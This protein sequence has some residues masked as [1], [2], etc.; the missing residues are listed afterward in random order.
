MTIPFDNLYDYIFD[1][2]NHNNKNLIMH[3]FSP[4]GAR[5]LENLIVHNNAEI[6]NVTINGEEEISYHY[7][8]MF[9]NDQEPLNFDFYAGEYA[10]NT[11]ENHFFSIE[12]KNHMLSHPL[13]KKLTFKRNI[14]GHP[15]VPLSIYD[16]KLILHSEKNSKDLE[17][18]EKNEF[19]GVYYWC[20]ALIAL[21]W[22]RFAKHDPKLKNIGRNTF[23]KSF[24]IYCR[25]WSGSREYRLS[26][27]NKM[28]T[29]GVDLDSAIHFNEYDNHIHFSEFVPENQT[30]NIT[31][32]NIK[33]GRFQKNNLSS[34]ALSATYD[35]SHYVDAAID[36][37]LETV[38]DAEKIHL[39]E[40]TLRPIACGKP[41]IIVSENGTLEYLKSYG[42]ETF[43]NL[44]DESYD[45]IT[46][47]VARMDA[48]TK[49]MKQISDLSKK[50]KDRLFSEMHCIA[51]RNKDWF[52][53]DEFFNIVTNE[54]KT[55]LRSALTELDDPKNQTGKEIRRY[56]RA[57]QMFKKYMPIE[58]KVLWDCHCITMP[59]RF[60]LSKKNIGKY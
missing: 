9:C 60:E 36:V 24:N 40:K 56:I 45:S 10:K 38:Y 14:A 57:F 6:I 42:F 28:I 26:L 25:A 34:S 46:D 51:K 3:R 22:Y 19:L 31:K 11:R 5:N 1:L 59:P 43:G 48:I 50:E 37:V 15:I 41:F 13:S 21:D 52:F 17:K 58:N 30:W 35:P 18:Y 47:P 23:N 33:D 12:G 7:K 20:H 44:I 2:T 55:N 49:T 8:L 39:T 54:L 16:K 29:N 32:N 4:H 27:L 53:S